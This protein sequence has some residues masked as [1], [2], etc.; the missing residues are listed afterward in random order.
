M[1]ISYIRTY[2]KVASV[3]SY[4]A[5]KLLYICTSVAHVFIEPCKPEK[6]TAH[7]DMVTE[8]TITLSWKGSDPSIIS[9]EVEYRKPGE[10]FKKVE[11]VSNLRCT[12]TELTP[13]TKYEFKV[14]AINSAGHGPFTDTVNQFTSKL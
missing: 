11:N 7:R 13:Y 3:A 14:A 9:Y 1:I 5:T 12:V 4:I 2:I 6:L 8:N 10:S